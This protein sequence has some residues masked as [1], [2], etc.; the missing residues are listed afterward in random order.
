MH[1]KYPNVV[2]N[3]TD[4]GTTVTT[5]VWPRSRR[6]RSKE[7]MRR[8]Y[9]ARARNRRFG[10]K[11]YYGP[12]GRPVRGHHPILRQELLDKFNERIPKEVLEPVKWL[13][14]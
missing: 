13:S 10:P 9:I 6:V 11:Q 8:V 7:E 1:R 5:M 3:E 14:T 2:V 4:T 12:G